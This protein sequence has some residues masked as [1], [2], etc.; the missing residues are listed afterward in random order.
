MKRKRN[1]QGV[2]EY[3]YDINHNYFNYI[4]NDEKAYI[5]GFI[6]ADGCIH[7]KVLTIAQ[8][9]DK[10]KN[11]L[12]WIKEKMESNHILYTKKPKKETH[13]TTYI[14]SITSPQIING[15]KS[16]GV[17]ENKK[18]D[19]EFPTN[20]NISQFKSFIRGYF[21]GDG[22][23]GI[24]N[25]KKIKNGK[26]YISKYLKLSFFGTKDFIESC[27]DLLPD[28]LKGRIRYVKNHAEI[29]WT[30]K[31]AR[32]FGKW[33]FENENLFKSLKYVKYNT[34]IKEY[35]E[36]PKLIERIKRKV[37]QFNLNGQLINEYKSIT[38]VKEKLGLSI[39]SNLRGRTKT[40]GGFIWKYKI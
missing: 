17:K 16:N 30:N 9:G 18:Y 32:N 31:K 34:Y 10:E 28:E 11:I 3:E 7:K 24:Y 36:T 15:L 8:S 26:K 22:C 21:D 38:E 1:E 20:L 12:L 19:S 35:N 29:I 27:N 2:F 13:K 33:L 5:L 25:E 39:S 37:V 4:N 40:C 23:V 14:L 6:F